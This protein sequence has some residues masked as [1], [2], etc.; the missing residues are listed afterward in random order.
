MVYKEAIAAIGIT[1]ANLFESHFTTTYTNTNYD[2][3]DY[4]VM[5][6]V[7]LFCIQL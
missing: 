2:M 5:N 6:L 4:Q 1:I 7:Y 3:L